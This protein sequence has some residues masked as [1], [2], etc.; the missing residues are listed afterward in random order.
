MS[1]QL[2]TWIEKISF[3]LGWKRVDFPY[4]CLPLESSNIEFCFRAWSH[5]HQ[6]KSGS[7]AC[8]SSVEEA[9]LLR[10]CCCSRIDGEGKAIQVYVVVSARP[11]P[12][13]AKWFPITQVMNVIDRKE[14]DLLHIRLFTLTNSTSLGRLL[15][16]PNRESDFIKSLIIHP[17][18][19]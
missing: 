19:M 13:R 2:S 14:D 8:P 18:S 16:V 4:A 3:E 6:K 10:S 9:T 17:N 1:L 12:H 5:L 11:R 15:V 7:G